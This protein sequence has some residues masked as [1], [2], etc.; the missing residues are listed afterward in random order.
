MTGW[1]GLA[2]AVMVAGVIVASLFWIGRVGTL[3]V[4]ARRRTALAHRVRAK[5]AEGNWDDEVQEWL[6]Q[7]L[8]VS[9]DRIREM[10]P[11]RSK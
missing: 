6:A 9:R 2:N 5:V 10:V 7:A 1:W 4:R 8:G 11:R 3:I